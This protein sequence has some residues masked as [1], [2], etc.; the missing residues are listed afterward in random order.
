MSRN[1]NLLRYD[2][3]LHFALL[4]TNWLP[5]NVIFLKLR[6]FLCR[7]FF[8]SCGSNL[9]LGR[10]ISFYNPSNITIGN[11]VYI[12]YNNWLSAG[13]S[14]TIGNKVNIGPGCVIASGSHAFKNGNFNEESNFQNEEIT[15]GSGSWVAGNVN[16]SGGTS[17]G[18]STLIASGCSVKG[19]YPNGVLL[20]TN[21]AVVKRNL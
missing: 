9:R 16:I 8:K 3:P 2:W 13:V 7:P 14:I 6:G 11:D 12:A 10:N 4:F 21:L 1:L 15:I 20:A 5:D 17:I 19:S 18:E